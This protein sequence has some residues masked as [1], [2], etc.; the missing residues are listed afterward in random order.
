[1]KLFEIKIGNKTY[2]FVDSIHLDGKNYVAYQDKENIY[3]NEF[4][5]EDEK[6]NFIE[7]DD[8]TF[9]KVKEAMSL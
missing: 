3:I 2:E 4:T 7:I 9:D 5:I 6:V 1:M 8:S